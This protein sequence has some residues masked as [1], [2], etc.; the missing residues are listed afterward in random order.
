MQAT[1]LT[2]LRHHSRHCPSSPVI[3]HLSRA[4]FLCSIQFNRNQTYSHQTPPNALPVIIVKPSYFTA[5]KFHNFVRKF[6]FVHSISQFKPE[7]QYNKCIYDT[8]EKIFQWATLAF[9]IAFCWAKVQSKYR[10]KSK[11][12]VISLSESLRPK[13][14]LS[15]YLHQS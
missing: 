4:I 6:T 7:K 3:V 9:D 14:G 10:L 12:I 8:S 15:T 2:Y 11:S 13:F 1:L 5:V